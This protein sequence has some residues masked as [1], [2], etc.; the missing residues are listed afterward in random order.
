MQKLMSLRP[1]WYRSLCARDNPEWSW[2]GL[3]AEEVA[4]IEPRLVQWAYPLKEVREEVP[5]TVEVLN[6]KTGQM[7]SVP[8][9]D[10]EGNQVMKVRVHYAGDSN[11]P[12]RPESV[13]YDRIA[14]LTLAYIQRLEARVKALEKQP[15]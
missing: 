2:Y 11:Q 13:M 15:K 5:R 1:I 12:K 6:K 7:D 9:L 10:K 4:E 14:V 8:V 3:I